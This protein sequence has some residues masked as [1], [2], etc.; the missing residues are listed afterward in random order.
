[1]TAEDVDVSEKFK[2]ANVLAVPLQA[3]PVLSNLSD[4]SPPPP[5]PPPPPPPPW[6]GEERRWREL[7]LL[8]PP[9]AATAVGSAA[10]GRLERVEGAAATTLRSVR[11]RRQPAATAAVSTEGEEEGARE[12]RQG[13]GSGRR[14]GWRDSVEVAAA[15]TARGEG[16]RAPPQLLVWE[17][18]GAT[19]AAAAARWGRS[20]LLWGEAAVIAFRFERERGGS[21]R[22]GGGK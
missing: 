5:T 4:P 2:S 12:A 15:T 22:V 17:G 1:M 14:R 19:T 13:R 3:V 16:G 20:P 11:G 18:E 6:E 9:A 21:G 7:P 10:G 8:D